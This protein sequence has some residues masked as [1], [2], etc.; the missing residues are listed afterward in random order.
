[1][2]D[3]NIDWK[4]LSKEE[5]NIALF[6]KQKELLDTFLE[7]HAITIEQYNKSLG[8]LKVKMGIKDDEK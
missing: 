4:S 2:E 1:M 3:K 5:K 8:D 7:H 6:N